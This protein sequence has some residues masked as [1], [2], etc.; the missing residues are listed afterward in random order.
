MSHDAKDI[1]KLIAILADGHWHSGESLG[2]AI[3]VT[4][5]AVWKRLQQLPA[6]GLSVASL[7]GHGY[8]LQQRC[9]LLNAGRIRDQLIS[10]ASELVAELDC[11]SLLPS[12]NG[13]LLN[14]ARAHGSVCLSEWQS[15]G[16]GRR[17]RNWYSPYAA[18]IYMSVRWHFDRGVAALDGLSLAVG[19]VIVEALAELGLYSV[20][21]KWPNDLLCSGAKLGGILIEVGG[22]LTGECAAVIGIGLNVDMRGRAAEV[23]QQAW[24]DLASQGLSVDRNDLCSALLN[25]LLP[26]LH[27]FQEQGFCVYRQRWMNY[28]A[29]LNEE[30]QLI[31]PSGARRGTFCGVDDRGAFAFEVD[32]Q[33]EWISGGEISLRGGTHAL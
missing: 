11:F 9:D 10:P 23:I 16:R 24:T 14:A 20:Q 7:K 33:R 30:V 18:N 8:R 3:G 5:A 22:D 31:T 2:S 19:V 26:A 27:R 32:G 1:F 13:Y 29:Y 28:A 4:R 21:L 12:T 6:M 17:G 15:S 25:R